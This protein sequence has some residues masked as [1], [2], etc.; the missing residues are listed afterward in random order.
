MHLCNKGRILCNKGREIAAARCKKALE[1]SVEIVSTPQG[2]RRTFI[3][4][5]RPGVRG[6]LNSSR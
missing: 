4:F 2:L 5:R 6:A 1:G 3:R